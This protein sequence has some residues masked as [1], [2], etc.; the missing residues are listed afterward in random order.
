M[1]PSF[2]RQPSA[3]IL[4]KSR[5]LTTVLRKS[6]ALALVTNAARHSIIS[7]LRGAAICLRFGTPSAITKGNEYDSGKFPHLSSQLAEQYQR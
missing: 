5:N 4:L 7:N 6:H 3:V 2:E 1:G